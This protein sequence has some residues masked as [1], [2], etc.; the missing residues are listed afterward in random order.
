MKTITCSFV[1]V[2]AVDEEPKQQC[3]VVARRS[4][5]EAMTSCKSHEGAAKGRS[6]RI[7]RSLMENVRSIPVPWGGSSEIITAS[8]ASV[9]DAPRIEEPPV[10]CTCTTL[11]E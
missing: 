9:Q 8:S 2:V 11:A 3:L 10:P 1:V 4:L 6:K 5:P 7:E